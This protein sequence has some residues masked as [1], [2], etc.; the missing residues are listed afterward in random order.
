MRFIAILLFIISPALA[1]VSANMFSIT[2]ANN[3]LTRNG[4]AVQLGGVLTKPTVVTPNVSNLFTING[5]QQIAG[6]LNIGAVNGTLGADQGQ[7]I[8][9]VNYFGAGTQQYFTVQT[10]IPISGSVAGMYRL[11]IK[12]YAYG[13]QDIIDSTIVFYNYVGAIYGAS[14]VIH[15]GSIRPTNV[16][17]ANVGGFV[18]IELDFGAAGV[19]YNRFAINAIAASQNVINSDFNGWTVVNT[20]LP[21]TATG[22]VIP[23]IKAIG[24]AAFAP[25][26]MLQNQRGALPIT[27]PTFTS[28]GGR[29]KVTFTGTAYAA[30]AATI[31]VNLAI[32]GV[33]R[34]SLNGY[35]NEGLSHKALHSTTLI[36]SGIAAG[37][38]TITLSAQA[39]TITDAND[40]FSCIVEELPQ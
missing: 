18:N 34:G 12:G 23:A 16:R 32:D 5:N 17:L 30:S 3:G 20:A 27:S 13:S 15:N 19:Y 24:G 1:Q 28:L 4:A 7:H 38:H 26:A 9:V 10:K 6:G 22:I 8:G 29:L 2:S 35:T 21:T 40:Y 33:V 11:E 37:T 39:G 14:S 36:L 31:G 25:K